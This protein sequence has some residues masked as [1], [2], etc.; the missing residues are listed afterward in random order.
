MQ[1]LRD[2]F[3]M[4]LIVFFFLRCGFA[5]AGFLGLPVRSPPILSMSICCEC[6]VLSGLCVGLITRL[7]ESSEYNVSVI[8]KR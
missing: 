8:V 3:T 4:V 1:P 7:E 6:C 5:A 2:L